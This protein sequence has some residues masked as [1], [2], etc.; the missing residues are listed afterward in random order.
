MRVSNLQPARGQ[1][2]A[3]RLTASAATT[4]EA[5]GAGAAL[6]AVSALGYAR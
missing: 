2:V 4:G 3:R 1:G 6:A 5:L